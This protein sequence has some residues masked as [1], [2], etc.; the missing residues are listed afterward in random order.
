[1]QT[2]FCGK[3]RLCQNTATTVGQLAPVISAKNYLEIGVSEGGTL[4]SEKLLTIEKKFGVDPNPS[5]SASLLEARNDITIYNTTSD[6]FFASHSRFIP[7][8]DICFIDG[9]H[10]FEQVIK[11]LLGALTCMTPK[12]III[13]DDIKPLSIA[14]AEA[15]LYQAIKLKSITGEETGWWLG[16]VYKIVPFVHVFLLTHSYAIIPGDISQLIIWKASCGR[17][18]QVYSGSISEISEM[19][20]RDFLL[21]Q[22]VLFNSTEISDIIALIQ[23]DL[24]AS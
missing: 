16:D 8:I 2:E 3:M 5:I 20:F 15:D 12:G 6:V 18:K 21:L 4:L 17:S 24:I 23:K 7:S 19:T 11:D 1:M 22:S 13:I 14:Q 9:L 10:T